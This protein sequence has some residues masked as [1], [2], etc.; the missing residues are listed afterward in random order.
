M[1]VNRW[2]IIHNEFHRISLFCEKNLGWS[3]RVMHENSRWLSKIVRDQNATVCYIY[4]FIII[5][6]YLV[7]LELAMADDNQNSVISTFCEDVTRS[8][9]QIWKGAKRWFTN[10]FSIKYTTN[11]SRWVIRREYYGN[12]YVKLFFGI[13]SLWMWIHLWQ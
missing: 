2:G 4:Y 6:C 5:K 10:E 12:V 13:I 11:F 1:T 8:I 3:K 7:E 9:Q